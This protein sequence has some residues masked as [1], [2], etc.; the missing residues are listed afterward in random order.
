PFLFWLFFLGFYLFLPRGIYEQS[1]FHP[2]ISLR[3]LSIMRMT[4]IT[5]LFWG[6]GLLSYSTHQWVILYYFLLWIVPMF[7]TFSFLTILQQGVQHANADQGWLS[8][9]RVFILNPFVE[10]CLFPFGLGYHQPH[11]MFPSVPQYHLKKLHKMLMDYPEYR[12]KATI[13]N[14][15]LF[16]P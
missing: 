1:H 7:T 8:N 14:G 2:V 6:L 3:T 11:H 5:A 9:S 16:S 4:Y 10:F 15:Y 13:V 12:E